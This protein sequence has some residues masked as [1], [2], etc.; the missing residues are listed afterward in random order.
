MVP[1]TM[2]G[3]IAL[4]RGVGVVG[5]RLSH[6][7]PLTGF[8]V[9]LFAVMLPLSLL[10]IF[11]S[12]YIYQSSGQV[13]DGEMSGFSTAFAHRG[14]AKFTGLRAPGERY[15]DGILGFERSRKRRVPRAGDLR[16]LQRHREELHRG[17][18]DDGLRR[19]ALPAD[20]RSLQGA[21][22]RGVSRASVPETRIQNAGKSPRRE[23]GAVGWRVRPLLHQMTR[24]HDTTFIR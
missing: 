11:H 4:A 16:Q 24:F 17:A 18:V 7:G 19:A 12:P 14:D 10:T 5:N 22:T 8:V 3:G 6:T 21:G 2:L 23:P 1:V 9:I 15:S 20:N 13:S